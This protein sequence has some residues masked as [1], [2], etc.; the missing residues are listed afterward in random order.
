ML[1]PDSLRS[2]V[3][4]LL[5]LTRAREHLPFVVPISL[6]G[7]LLGAGQAQVPL[8][9]RW[10]TVST[11]NILAVTYAFMINDIED[12]HDD[13]ASPEGALRNAVSSGAISP[14]LGWVASALVF[15]SSLILYALAGGMT[16]LLGST[17]LA[18]SHFYSWRRIRLKSVFLVDVLSHAL[19]LGG[20]LMLTG[21]FAYG[22]SPGWGWSLILAIT[23]FSAYGQLYNQ[24][25][26]YHADRAVGLRTTTV[27]L[28]TKRAVRVMYTTLGVSGL[29]LLVAI[30]KGQLPILMLATFCIVFAVS[31]FRSS[32]MV[33]ARGSPVS[34]FSGALQ[35]RGLLATNSA[36]VLWLTWSMLNVT[37]SVAAVSRF[38]LP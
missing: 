23:F 28:G 7:A 21:F 29:F 2:S 5:R 9:W 14:G 17:I 4:G 22:T 19:M 36:V 25:R 3:I 1:K 27:E 8:G 24:V 13:L 18:I 32:G 6:I 34:D 33:D 11:A 31:S 20:L 12:S 30:L 37:D 35:T 10:V 38:L 15:A 16:L 26:D